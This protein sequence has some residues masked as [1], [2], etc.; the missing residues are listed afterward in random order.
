MSELLPRDVV[1]LVR[2]RTL[3]CRTGILLLP[4]EQLGREAAL[5]ARLNTDAVDFASLKAATFRPE[6]RF[7]RPDRDMLIR[8]LDALCSGRSAAGEGDTDCFFIYNFDLPLAALDR[9]E[10]RAL[11]NFLRDTFRKR[12]KGLVFSLP[13]TANEL[14]PNELEQQLWQQGGRWSCAVSLE[15]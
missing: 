3:D 15:P 9:L 12:A 11:W 13:Q 2:G 4:K 14:L 6:A 5:A 8:D 10:R 7:I 1:K